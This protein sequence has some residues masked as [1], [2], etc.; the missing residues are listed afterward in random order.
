M[1]R[2]NKLENLLFCQGLLRLKF[3][4]ILLSFQTEFFRSFKRNLRV[5]IYESV[6]SVFPD[7]FFGCFAGTR[8]SSNKYISSHPPPNPPLQ[9]C[10]YGKRK[11]GNVCNN[12]PRFQ[13]LT[14]F[15][16]SY[17]ELAVFSREGGIFFSMYPF[18]FCC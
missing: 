17:R 11:C 4:P 16:T 18:F 6:V 12:D 10:V 7:F 14:L 3:I 1:Y 8:S 5:I 13:V 2:I 15:P 9:P